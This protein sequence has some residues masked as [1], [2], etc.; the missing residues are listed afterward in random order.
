MGF[1]P[2]ASLRTAPFAWTQLDQDLTDIGEGASGFDSMADAIL[3]G[4]PATP[5][6]IVPTAI[7]LASSDSDYITGQ[8][9]PIEGGMILV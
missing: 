4:R 2:D 3:L 1:L 6:D 8:V 9:I 5:D 7:F